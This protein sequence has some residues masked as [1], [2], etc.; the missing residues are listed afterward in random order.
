M[1]QRTICPIPILSRTRFRSYG[2]GRGVAPTEL[3]RFRS[4]GAGRGFAP[5]ELAGVSLLRSCKGFAPT[6]L[7]HMVTERRVPLEIAPLST[8][9]QERSLC[10]EQTQLRRS[11]TFVL[12]IGFFHKP[13]A[14]Q[15][16][17][18]AIG[19]RRFL[20]QLPLVFFKQHAP[21]IGVEASFAVG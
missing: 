6:E 2:A 16:P 19:T 9:P 15:H 4:Y 21:A 8:A 7:L 5:T 3:Q 20:V 14:L 18:A 11:V 12:L 1:K 13:T 10:T 17:K